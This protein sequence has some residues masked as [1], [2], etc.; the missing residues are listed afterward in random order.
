MAGGIVNIILRSVSQGSG[1]Q[2]HIDG[3]RELTNQVSD[4]S[5]AGKKLGATFGSLGSLAGD[6]FSNILKGGIWGAMAAI[7]NIGISLFRKWRDAAKEAAEEA[8]KAQEAAAVRQQKALENLAE[9]QRKCASA[10]M[11]AIADATKQWKAERD[12][13]NDLAKA[14]LELERAQARLRGDSVGT[15]KADAEIAALDAAEQRRAL[16][17]N[18]TDARRRL[19]AANTEQRG[20]QNRAAA[21]DRAAR[22]AT[23]GVFAAS[24]L[25][26]RE[27]QRDRNLKLRDEAKADEEKARQKARAAQADI[28]NAKAAIEAFDIRTQ[29]KLV[30]EAA[31][32]G[33]KKAEAEKKAAED[34]Q[35]ADAKAA[36]DRQKAEIA[37]AQAVAKERARLEQEAHDQRMADLRAEIA[38][39]SKAAARQSAVASAA[40]SEFDKAFAMYRDPSRAAAVIGEEQDYRNDLDRLHKDARRY[41][42]KWRIDELSSLMAAGDTQGVSD[43]LATWRKS[44][45]FTPE[46]EAMVRAS[47]AE[48]TKTTAEDELRRLNEET[49]KL[50]EKL[51]ELSGDNSSKLGEIASSTSGLAAKIDEL[52]SVKG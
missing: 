11:S 51:S 39:Q 41:G 27:A 36:D 46:V 19:D 13:V 40:Q 38:E 28:K 7:A 18:L 8:A 42:G 32:A 5:Q 6:L 16:V 25:K 50:N 33:E 35:K 43:T 30:D 45:G 37:A 52:L 4:L 10:R 3:A 48:Q 47:A 14:T 15:Q 31:Q 44:K 24:Q 49:A 21:A 23:S 17:R 2:K 26:Q 12:A 9:V 29:A 1:F 22:N 20:A 34:R